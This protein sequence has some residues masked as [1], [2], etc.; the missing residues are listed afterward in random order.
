MEFLT[1]FAKTKT[2]G[3]AERDTSCQ[4]RFRYNGD[5]Y[6]VT[7]DTGLLETRRRVARF[8]TA[9]ENSDRIGVDFTNSY[10]LL[11]EAF[12]IAPD[13]T[14]PV[15]PSASVWRARSVPWPRRGG[16]RP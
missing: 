14:I 5:R 1:Y 3:I 7:A 2:P 6:A 9:F 15:G 11:E 8:T 4:G 16:A 12:D 10:E 13:V